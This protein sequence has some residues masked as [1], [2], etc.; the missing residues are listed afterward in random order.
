MVM[1]PYIPQRGDIVWINFTPQMGR[2]QAGKRPALVISPFDYNKK[3]G[4]A[5]FCP[6]TSHAKGYPFEVNIPEGSKINGVVLTDQLKSLDFKIRK[7]QFV[8]KLSSVT[9]QEVL[10][11]INTLLGS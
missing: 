5:L 7:I 2:E 9:M 4:L 8:C 11:K 6:I 3:V 1:V 10:S